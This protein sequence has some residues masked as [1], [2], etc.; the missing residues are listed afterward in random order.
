MLEPSYLSN[1][2]QLTYKDLDF[3]RLLLRVRGFY[4]ML[5]V[6]TV[7]S[8]DLLYLTLGTGHWL[9]CILCGEGLREVL[10]ADLHSSHLPDH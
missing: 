5:P 10:L 4:A 9:L 1:V 7:H 6:I 3:E 8:I 2:T